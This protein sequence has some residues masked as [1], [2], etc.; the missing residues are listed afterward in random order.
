MAPFLITTARLT[1]RPV[2]AE[3]WPAVQKVWRDFDESEYRYYDTPKDISDAAVA[4][5]IARWAEAAGEWEEHLFFAVCL[6]EAVIGYVS[7]NA[8]PG[9]YELGYGFQSAYHGRGYAKEALA[10]ILAFMKERGTGDIYA[11]TALL[12]APSVRLLRSLGFVRTGTERLAFRKD[13]AGNGV[14]FEGGLFALPLNGK[15]A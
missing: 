5:R 12:N 2:S 3:D 7:L 8:R 10:A 9:G 14:F 1:V 11:G 15:N 4:S 6:G 13:A